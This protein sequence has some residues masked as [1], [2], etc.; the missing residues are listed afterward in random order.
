MMKEELFLEELRSKTHLLHKRV[1]QTPF[2]RA[3]LSPSLKADQYIQY[4]QRLLPVHADTEKEVFPVLSPYLLDIQERKKS[5]KIVLDLHALNAADAMKEE[6]T[7]TFLDQHFIP[8][9][10]FCFG[11]MYVVEGSTLGGLYISRHLMT[12]VA[13][14]E[15]I[16]THFLNAYGQHTGNKWKRFLDALN[17]YAAS[18]PTKETTDIVNGA[19]YGFNRT[20]ELFNA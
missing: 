3:I 16:S 5:D 14:D 9:I 19:V 8:N 15:K 18:V 12:T 13:R 7:F 20:F 11:L 10:P 1:E 17:N 2:S 6:T 4:L